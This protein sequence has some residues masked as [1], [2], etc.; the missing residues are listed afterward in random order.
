MN[1]NR[2]LREIE[3]EV[4]ALEEVDSVFRV[5]FHA[6]G[7]VIA[8]D[9]VGLVPTGAIAFAIAERCSRCVVGFQ[10]HEVTAET[11]D[12]FAVMLMAG[13]IAER[14]HA[15]KTKPCK[16]PD[17]LDLVAY[18]GGWEDQLRL[19][20]EAQVLG[21]TWYERRTLRAAADLVAEEWPE[22]QRLAAR[23]ATEIYVS[24]DTG[25]AGVSVID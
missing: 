4:V 19:G 12:A 16:Q 8:G 21:V 10:P 18:F 1:I 25:K 15:D 13:P 9:R 11:F 5:A 23:L 24:F 7:H 6:A 14:S 22:I 20:H 2:L 3:G 17:S